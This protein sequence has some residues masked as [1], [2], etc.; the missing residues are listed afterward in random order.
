MLL[1]FGFIATFVFALSDLF[2]KKTKR[3]LS[4]L[5][6]SALLLCFQRW[7]VSRTLDEPISDS[8]LSYIVRSANGTP[9]WDDLAKILSTRQPTLRDI[10]ELQSRRDARE[11]QELDNDEAERS[12]ARAAEVKKTVDHARAQARKEFPPDVLQD[13]HNQNNTSRPGTP[14]VYD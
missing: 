11:Q 7:E 2:E 4:L 5:A 14:G 3:G 12:A 1:L 10:R 13:A 9:E 8:D 6:L